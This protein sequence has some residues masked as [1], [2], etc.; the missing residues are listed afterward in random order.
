MA[1]ETSS[2]IEETSSTP[3]T[4]KPAAYEVGQSDPGQPAAPKIPISAAPVGSSSVP[5]YRAP[6]STLPQTITHAELA[7][8][9]RAQI[10]GRDGN[11]AW[12]AK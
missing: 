10:D 6:A 12:G 9:G 2:G 11:V 3:L 5:E 8:A 7:D 4:G 1:K